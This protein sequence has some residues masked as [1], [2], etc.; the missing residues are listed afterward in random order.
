MSGRLF[1]NCHLFETFLQTLKFLDLSGNLIG[2]TGAQN[3]A[4]ALQDNTVKTIL[5]LRKSF[6]HFD[7][8]RN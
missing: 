2:D 3:L 6:D 8:N 1:I 5:P 7:L 4:K